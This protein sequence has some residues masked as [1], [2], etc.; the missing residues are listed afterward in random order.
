[1]KVMELVNRALKIGK[2]YRPEPWRL[3]LI[4][5][6]PVVAS[7]SEK[8]CRK[9]NSAARIVCHMRRIMDDRISLLLGT[10]FPSPILFLRSYVTACCTEAR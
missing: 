5:R 3:H 1:M 9:R 6:R 10:F 8:Q 7:H 2:L 4:H